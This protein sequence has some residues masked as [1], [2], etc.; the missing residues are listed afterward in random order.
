MSR[1]SRTQ[2]I[3]RR[4][5]TPPL[6][7][8][9][10]E[11]S[12]DVFRDVRFESTIG[13]ATGVLFGTR[14]GD[15]VRILAARRTDDRKDPRLKGL[16]SVGIFIARAREDLS[17][18]EH[19]LAAFDAAKVAGAVI[20]VVAGSSGGFFTRTAAG[21]LQAVEAHHELPK[22]TPALFNTARRWVWI[23]AGCLTLCTVAIAAPGYLRP[24]SSPGA[25]GLSVREEAGQ[26]RIGWTRRP[27]SL[28]ILDG[29]D[30]T[31]IRLAGALVNAT[32]ARRTSDVEIRLIDA[33][34]RE[35][36][37]FLGADRRVEVRNQIATLESEARALRGVAQ[38]RKLRIVELSRTTQLLRELDR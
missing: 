19:D 5:C 28:E 4:I 20:L 32:Y 12:A 14:C 6:S 16:E 38:A 13:E 31:S 15:Q 34:K 10:I 7:Q 23:G 22:I 2:P 3:E 37:R 21:S 29:A 8:L 30:R 26:L 24:R 27:A 18:S 36:A 33:S 17:L 11:Y 25:F 1:F 9:R 35:T